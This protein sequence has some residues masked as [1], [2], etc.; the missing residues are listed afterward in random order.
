[1]SHDN[2]CVVF[3]VKQPIWIDPSF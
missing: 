3:S 2:S 1:M